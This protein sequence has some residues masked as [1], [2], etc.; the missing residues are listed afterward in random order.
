MATVITAGNATNGLSLSADNTG[1]FDFKTGSGAGTS[2]MT[3]SSSQ[4]VSIPGNLTVSGTL[5]ASGGVSGSI[6][7][8]TAVSASGTSVTFTGIR[9]G[10]KRIT[11]MLQGVSGNALASLYMQIGTSSGLVATGY[12]GGAN[13][14][15][16][17]TNI[18]ANTYWPLDG[19]AYGAASLRNGT[20]TITN[21]TGNTWVFSG[22]QNNSNDAG[23]SVAG[24]SLA[25]SAVLDRVSIGISAGAFDAGS[26]NILYE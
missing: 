23:A 8:G 10:V 12:L 7:S 4:V 3:I 15:P 19:A 14:L 16:T 20:F 18:N 26:I 9:S 6:T 1:S 21:I 25:L 5:T 13:Y 17:G 2:A 22:N 24:G 11:V